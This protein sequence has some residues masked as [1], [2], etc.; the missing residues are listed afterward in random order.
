MIKQR[1]NKNSKNLKWLQR[2]HKKLKLLHLQN[3]KKLKML[4]QTGPNK[5]LQLRRKLLKI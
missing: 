1:L 4:L 5:L 3:N 2:E